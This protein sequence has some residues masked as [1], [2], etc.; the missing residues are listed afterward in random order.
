MSDRERWII[1]PL[2]FFSMALGLKDTMFQEAHHANYAQITTKQLKTHGASIN[3]TLK[4]DNIVC[5]NIVC[6]DLA[7]ATP[8]GQ[9]IISLSNQTNGQGKRSGKI[10]LYASNGKLVSQLGYQEK[11]QTGYLQLF[12]RQGQLSLPRI[13]EIKKSKP[14]Q[15]TIKQK[16]KALPKIPDKT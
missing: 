5:R 11:A 2:L 15:K 7:V 3:H 6:R 8:D 9:K 13:V 1:Y 14:P 12:H 10:S 16:K 4:V